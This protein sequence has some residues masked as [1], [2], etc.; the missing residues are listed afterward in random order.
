MAAVAYILDMA[1]DKR[2]YISTQFEGVYYRIST[3]RDPRTGDYD[4]IYCFSYLDPFKKLHWKTVGRHSEG[5]RVQTARAARVEFLA[6]LNAGRNPIDNAAVTT[7]DAIDAYVAWA[8]AEGKH[9]DKPLQQY[10]KHIRA[11]IHAVPISSITTG[12]LT[13][14]RNE[15]SRTMSPQSVHHHFSFLRRV[16]NHAIRTNR[17]NGIN[18]VAS[19]GGWKMPKVNNGRLRFF[20]PEEAK[21]LLGK[22]AQRSPQLHDMAL[23][24]LKTGLR[25]TEIF[26]LRWEDIDPRGNVLHVTAKGGERQIVHAPRAV[27]DMLLAYKRRP[28]E[29]IF[30][31]R[32]TGNPI[33]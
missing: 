30:Q 11:R 21:T 4:R 24:S 2:K 15:L 17:W 5:V 29:Y 31:E 13:T 7:G 33:R 1:Q 10:D 14:I 25:A 19:Q 27:I 9:V 23:L 32:T 26:K 3:K 6:E 18:P 16:I 28:G 22:L 20:T 8:R 12:M